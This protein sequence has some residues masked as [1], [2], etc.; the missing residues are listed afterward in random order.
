MLVVSIYREVYLCS[1]VSK[2]MTA[3]KT[4]FDLVQR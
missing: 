4:T 1:L 3:V 2:Q